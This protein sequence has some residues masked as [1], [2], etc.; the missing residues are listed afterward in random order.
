MGGNTSSSADRK[1]GSHDSIIRAIAPGH[2]ARTHHA[3]DPRLQRIS[4]LPPARD[5]PQGAPI[6]AKPRQRAP[7]FTI[8]KSAE[9][10]HLP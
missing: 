7:S 3:I 4:L 5:A 8:I 1:E 2:L 6:H 10:S 9:Q